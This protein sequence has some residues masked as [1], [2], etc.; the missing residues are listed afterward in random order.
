MPLS[1]EL[2]QAVRDRIAQCPDLP[3]EQLAAELNAPEAD[4]ITALP[5]SMRRK[6]RLSDLGVI[7]KRAARWKNV[8]I[9]APAATQP[10]QGLPEAIAEGRLPVRSAWFVSKPVSGM[11]SH[12]IHMYDEQGSRMLSLYLGRDHNGGICPEDKADFDELREHYG[13]TPKP[14]MRC[15]GCTACTC[16]GHAH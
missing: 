14:R 1:R 15:K 11:E 16:G 13:V 2:V 9:S 12:A 8:R 4:V 5:L 3:E 10:P 6:A 7:W